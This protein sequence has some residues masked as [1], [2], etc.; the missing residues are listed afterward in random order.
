MRLKGKSGRSVI[1]Y[2]FNYPWG[3]Y[4]PDNRS[5]MQLRCNEKANCR[6]ANVKKIRS[7]PV[8]LAAVD[9]HC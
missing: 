6:L 1:D 7:E 2:A 9:I 8:N 5:T 3:T 4:M